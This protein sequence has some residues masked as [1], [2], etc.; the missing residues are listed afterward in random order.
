MLLLLTLVV[1]RTMSGSIGSSTG[2]EYSKAPPGSEP[3]PSLLLDSLEAERGFGVPE[4][5]QGSSV[6]PLWSQSSP[7]PGLG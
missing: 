5:E 6:I 1:F 7:V 3:L 2:E 4:R